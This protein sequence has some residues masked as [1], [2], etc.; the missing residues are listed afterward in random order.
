MSGSYLGHWLE[1]PVSECGWRTGQVEKAWHQHLPVLHQSGYSILGHRLG[2]LSIY[3]PTA[4]GPGGLG[5]TALP[6]H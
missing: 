2:Q 1:L 4:V 3:L 5:W 6:S